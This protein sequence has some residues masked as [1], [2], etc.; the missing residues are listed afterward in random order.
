[1]F[2][3]L[4][5][6]VYSYRLTE[7]VQNPNV[8]N[9]ISNNGF[10]FAQWNNPGYANF[11]QLILWSTSIA[12]T[13][14]FHTILRCY[15]FVSKYS[16]VTL[17]MVIIVKSLLLLF[18]MAASSLFLY[19]FLVSLGTAIFGKS[20]Y[21]PLML[22]IMLSSPVISTCSNALVNVPLVFTFGRLEKGS[23]M[24]QVFKESLHKVFSRISL[25]LDIFCLYHIV[26][27]SYLLNRLAL[28]TTDNQIQ[29]ITSSFTSWDPQNVI[30]WII[31][32]NFALN[33]LIAFGAT[34]I[35]WTFR[36]INHLL[37]V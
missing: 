23:T 4:T 8:L 15:F 28:I 18:D 11:V 25:V 1:M 10:T 22:S 16:S 27:Q 35:Y 2:A 24:Q 32:V 36:L 29:T 13:L 21:I 34:I 9:T 26:I 6:R 17:G 33:Y 7:L 19:T 3:N 31:S 20:P 5:L 12:I 30:I 14:L 37:I